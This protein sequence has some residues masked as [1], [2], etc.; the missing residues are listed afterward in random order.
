L[1]AN[2]SATA[3]ATA[4]ASASRRYLR[5]IC[6]GC[7]QRKTVERSGKLCKS[8]QSNTEVYSEGRNVFG[9]PINFAERQG[10]TDEEKKRVL[11]VERKHKAKAARATAKY[12]ANLKSL[13]AEVAARAIST[14]LKRDAKIKAWSQR[15]P[16]AARA[17]DQKQANLKGA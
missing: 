16:R 4:T 1:K 6:I 14:K 5:C 11:D 17:R 15:N 9:W 10:L 13:N 7:Q 12:Q 3:T 2:A 8:C